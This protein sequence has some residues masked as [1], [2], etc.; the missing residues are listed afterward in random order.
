MKIFVSYCTKTPGIAPLLQAV[1]QAVEEVPGVHALVD[2]QEF[3]VGEDWRDSLARMI[4][5]AQGSI[6]LLSP[7]A[8]ISEMVQYEAHCVEPKARARGHYLILPIFVAGP[9][10]AFSGPWANLCIPDRQAIRDYESNASLQQKV[11]ERVAQWKAGYPIAEPSPYYTEPL[12]TMGSAEL[13]GRDAELA[14]IDSAWESGENRIVCFVAAG[15]VGKSAL[16]KTWL[17][18]IRAKGYLGAERVYA[19]SF[20]SQGTTEKNVSADPFL[21]HA[22]SW[23]GD[24]NPSEGSGE[25]KGRRLS[26]LIKKHNSILIL[27][28]LEP[29]QFPPGEKEGHLKSQ[30]LYALLD[31]LIDEPG[32]C[33]TLISTRIRVTQILDRERQ[34]VNSIDLPPLSPGA[35]AQLLRS[36]KVKE[37]RAGELEKISRDFGGH[38]LALFLLGNYLSLMFGGHTHHIHSIDPL[39]Y[40]DNHPARH[41]RRVMESYVKWFRDNSKWGE[42]ELLLVMGLFDKPASESA[43]ASIR[44]RPAIVSLTE[45]ISEMTRQDWALTVDHLRRLGL[46]LCEN[47]AEPYALDAHPLVREFFGDRLRAQYPAA[48]H[49]G[50]AR[51]LEHYSAA[52]EEFPSDSREMAVLYAAV[53]HACACG[54]HR[55]AFQELIYRR[56]W[57]KRSLNRDDHNFSTRKLGLVGAD[58]VALA[59]FFKTRWNELL[60]GLDL[61]DQLRIFTDTGVRLRAL[62]RLEDAVEA[63][64]AA[65]AIATQSLNESTE[66]AADGAYAAAT[67]CELELT[68]GDLE[69]ARRTGEQAVSYA[70][71]SRDPFFVMHSRSA[72]ADVRMQLNDYAGARAM[73]DEARAL[74]PGSPIPFL[75]SQTCYRYGNFLVETG[76]PEQMIALAK[77]TPHWGEPTRPSSSLLSRAIDKLTLARAYMALGGAACSPRTRSQLEEAVSDLAES[78]YTDYLVRGLTTQGELLYRLGEKEAA[79]RAWSKGEFEADR[80]AMHLLSIDLRL[81][82]YRCLAGESTSDPRLKEMRY[83]LERAI[84]RLGYK[85]GLAEFTGARGVQH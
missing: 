55:E 77:S 66:L 11:T 49:D 59:Q 42:I 17:A 67:L 38:S 64:R 58:F 62:G 84:H 24:P 14:Y 85:K 60:P 25:A 73:F 68:R 21:Q 36:R 82:R 16:C 37:R 34:S 83:E 72:L 78:G 65:V 9:P 70:D 39:M 30:A 5:A 57:R 75:H 44:R 32:R 71:L 7:E 26:R 76:H 53:N 15:G 47:P 50:H 31:G 81:T 18:S 80:G 40:G 27:D 20:Y 56:A 79:E 54:R 22:L 41:A 29:L 43:L 19:W 48:W 13:F 51:L 23:F 35:G 2:Q 61:S 52:T 6:F 1:I 28:G 74:E 45:H 33:L 8:I 3:P 10:P 69:S 4:E 46:V 63:L 12:P